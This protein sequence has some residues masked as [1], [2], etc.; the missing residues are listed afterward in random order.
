MELK[1]DSQQIQTILNLLDT[2]IIKGVDS[3][4]KVVQIVQILNRPVGNKENK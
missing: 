1:Y 4:S 3:A 2:I